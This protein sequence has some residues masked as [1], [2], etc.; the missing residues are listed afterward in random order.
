[1][2]FSEKSIDII[3]VPHIKGTFIYF[4]LKDNEVV[5][6]GQ[7]KS[8]LDRPFQHKDKDFDMVKILPCDESEL[9]EM[10]DFYILKYEPKYNK[11]FSA[12][13]YIS[14]QYARTKL[15]N[16]TGDK[17]VTQ[18]DV[19]RLIALCDVPVFTI[20]GKD[21]ISVED[22]D[23]ILECLKS[24]ISKEPGHW[25]FMLKQKAKGVMK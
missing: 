11:F 22:Y 8:G 15:R 7:T 1:M 25:S 10:E 24:E 2:T 5:Y 18:Y 21:R 12:S 3:T 16:D 23:D 20:M 9:N 17:H 14:I 13:T 19:R 6:V 4:L